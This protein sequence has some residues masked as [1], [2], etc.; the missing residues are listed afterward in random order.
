MQFNW[1]ADKNAWLRKERGISFEEILSRMED[2]HLLDVVDH[3]HQERYP[4]QRFLVVDVNDYC[5]LVPFVL[6]GDECFLK[7]IIP[8][9]K[10]TRLYKKGVGK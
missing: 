7:T 8:S 2:G 10:F 9:R 3:P 6:S 4:G 5:Y 1:N